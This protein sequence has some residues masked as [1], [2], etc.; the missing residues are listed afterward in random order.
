MRRALI[1]TVPAIIASAMTAVLLDSSAPLE[2]A[3][4]AV[5]DAP[6]AEPQLPRYTSDGALRR[7]VGYETWILAGSSIGLGYTEGMPHADDPGMFHRVYISR[8][9]YEQYRK[10]GTF[11][12]KTMMVMALYAA[13]QKVAPSK[14]GYFE[15]DFIG[16]E[17]AVKDTERHPEGWAYY[18]F[19]RG[20]G[21]LVDSAQAFPKT[22]C[23]SCHVVHGRR[24]N[25]FTQFYPLLRAADPRR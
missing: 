3:A 2:S 16:L 6:A 23:Y 25:V 9:A 11:P 14:Q 21:T 10:T 12:E 24:D 7:P 17:A 8:T 22:A 13:G 19:T 18:N 20:M 1:A 4:G 15:G 5:E